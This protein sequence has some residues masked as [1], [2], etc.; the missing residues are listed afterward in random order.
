MEWRKRRVA[1]IGQANAKAAPCC[2]AAIGGLVAAAWRA[3]DA[4]PAPLQVLRRWSGTHERVELIRACWLVS[5]L[6]VALES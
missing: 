6:C 3:L 2:V 1:Q 5:A 4:H